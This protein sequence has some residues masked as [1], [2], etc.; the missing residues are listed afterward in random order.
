MRHADDIQAVSVDEALIE[1]TT[2][3]SR[4]AIRPSSLAFVDDPARSLAEQI[5]SE[6]QVAKVLHIDVS[7]ITY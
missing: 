4:C 1:V 7:D 5:R 2:S 6:E 3:V